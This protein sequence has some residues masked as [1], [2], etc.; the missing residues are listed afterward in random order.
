MIQAQGQM[1][2]NQKSTGV[3]EVV[4]G[5]DAT[6]SVGTLPCQDGSVPAHENITRAEAAQRATVISVDG[7]DVDLDL[8]TGPETF[9]ST[10]TVAF[11]CSEPGARS[12]IDLIAPE[13][14]SVNLNGTELDP[15]EVFDGARIELPDL[16]PANVLI[17]RARCAYMRTGEGL[18]RFVDP[19]DEE[20]YLYTQ[21][22]SADA[23]RMYACFEQPD[24]KAP[25]TLHV[26]A[27]DHWQVVSNAAT[28]QPTPIS[29]GVARWDFA[30][31][32]R[33]STYITALVAGPYHVERDS[34]T[35]SFGTYPLGV[36]CR[37]SLAP[38]LDS[39]EIFAITK[40]GFAFFEDLFGIGYPFGKY[41]QLFVPEFNAGAMENAG[42]VTFLEDYVFRSRVTDAAYEQRSNTILH[43]MAHMWFGD[44]VTMTWWDDLWLNESFAEWAAHHANVNATRFTDAWTTFSN[45][46]KAWAYRQDQLPSTHPIAAD[47]VDLDSVRVN[48]D[49]ITYAKGASALRQLVAW[50]GEQEFITGLIAYFTKHAWGNTRLEDLLTELEAA[51][52][53]DLSDWT[54]QWLQTSGV[55]LLTADFTLEDGVFTSMAIIQ[56]PPSSPEGVEPTLRSHRLALGL[57]DLTPEGLRRRDRIEIDVVGE[58]TEVPELIGSRQP[59]L[60]LI[61]DDDLTFAKIRL[62]ERSWQTAIAHIGDLDDSLAR[63]LIWGAAWDMTRDGE[64]STGDFLDLVIAGVPNEGEISVVQQTLRQLR[65]AIDLYATPEH[66]DGYQLRVADALH[67]WLLAAEAGSDRQLA[68]MRSFAASATTPEHLDVLEGVLAGAVDLPGLAVDAD[69]RWSLVQR[70]AA[71]GRIELDRIEQELERDDTATGRRQAALARAA[72]PSPE[73]KAL[74]WAD[75]MERSDLPNA[76]LDATIAGF[77]QPDQVD[78]LMP[79]RDRFF[80]EVVAAWDRQTM[81]MGQTIAMGLYPVLLVDEATITATDEFLARDDLNPALRR[82]VLE[83]RDGVLRAMRARSADV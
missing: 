46:R 65:M 69:L 47:M 72:R 28:P 58:R 22:E 42:C 45:L 27:P 24:L 51:S 37:T 32:P 77:V 80:A 15:A 12:W 57:Y 55:N 26:T 13:V 33:M 31:T 4:T 30:A 38:H 74:A 75:A 62:D 43:E 64:A 6:E 71:T 44:L 25:F 14:V 29:E 35:G 21:F 76:M 52:G 34:Y 59:D 5:A 40:A 17:V 78:L 23:R 82:L 16:Q 8:T 66:R 53:R 39:A 63:A 56:Q 70:L 18:H 60:L 49:G 36:F 83:G 68:F 3:G 79:Y 11:T 67:G 41:D 50:V 19:V 1:G 10:T 20:V 7:Y 54:R 73:A 61:N 48:F 81:E 2:S 9:A